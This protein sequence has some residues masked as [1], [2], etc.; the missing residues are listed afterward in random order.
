MILFY[1]APVASMMQTIYASICGALILIT[2]LIPPAILILD[3][4]G[5]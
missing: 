3:K 5:F 4:A 1:P 2:A